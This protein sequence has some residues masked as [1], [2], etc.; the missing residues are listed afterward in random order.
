MKEAVSLGGLSSDLRCNTCNRILRT[1]TFNGATCNCGG[2]A[3]FR[4]RKTLVE[5]VLFWL[6]FMQRPD[7]S[8]AFGV[9]AALGGEIEAHRKSVEHLIEKE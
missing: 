7:L 9:N 5:A 8:K 4:T 6:R 1:S 3:F 2:T